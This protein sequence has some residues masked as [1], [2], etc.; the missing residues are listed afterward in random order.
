MS[1]SLRT[2]LLS[3]FIV[4][5]AVSSA[6]ASSVL[7]MQ[8]IGSDNGFWAAQSNWAMFKDGE[9][10]TYD[11]ISNDIKKIKDGIELYPGGFTASGDLSVDVVI[12][13][14][15]VITM[16]RNTN[17]A[18]G[19]QGISSI[20]ISADVTLNMGKNS[21][22]EDTPSIHLSQDSKLRINAEHLQA[23]KIKNP[24]TWEAE[25]ADLALYMPVTFTSSNAS[26]DV[27]VNNGNLTIGNVALLGSKWEKRVR[28]ISSGSSALLAF[29]V[30]K[31]V[32]G[33][34]LDVILTGGATRVSV[35]GSNELRLNVW[36]TDIMQAIS[37]DVSFIKTGTGTL[38]INKSADLTGN[39]IPA[40][41]ADTIT[42]NGGTLKITG[43]GKAPIKRDGSKVSFVVNDASILDLG[44]KTIS[45]DASVD[46]SINKTGKV[47]FS[48]A[49]IDNGDVY[50]GGKLSIDAE[51]YVTFDNT[52]N[53]V[54]EF[55]GSQAVKSVKGKGTITSKG[56]NAFLLLNGTSADIKNFSGTIDGLDI[57]IITS[58][59]TLPFLGTNA[60]A[61]GTI[62]TIYVFG[63]EG[64]L[65]LDSKKLAGIADINNTN[66]YLR[67]DTPGIGRNNYTLLDNIAVGI[68]VISGD[69]ALG[70][71]SVDG[72]RSADSVAAISFDT[73][74]SRDSRLVVQKLVLHANADKDFDASNQQA[75]NNNVYSNAYAIDIRGRGTFA[76][77]DIVNGA[78]DTE[79]RIG[80][81]DS[82]TV[83]DNATLELKG[84]VKFP[85][86]N[87]LLLKGASLDVA[88]NTEIPG[89][90]IIDGNSI[91]KVALTGANEHDFYGEEN[92]RD[93]AIQV[94]DMF[95]I[96]GSTD[97]SVDIV[98]L[99]DDG[100]FLGKMYSVLSYS[101]IDLA[102]GRTVANVSVDIIGDYARTVSTDKDAMN[103]GLSNKVLWAQLAKW[104]IK[105]IVGQWEFI[106]GDDANQLGSGTSQFMAQISYG[107]S[108]DITPESIDRAISAD[109]TL[110]YNDLPASPRLRLGDDRQD[111]KT[112]TGEPL[113][114]FMLSADRTNH[115]FILSG[116]SY[117]TELTTEIKLSWNKASFDAIARTTD[118]RVTTSTG[119]ALGEAF[120]HNGEVKNEDLVDAEYSRKL[121]NPEK[122][123]DVYTNQ[124]VYVDG[125]QTTFEEGENAIFQFI[126]RGMR[127]NPRRNTTY[128]VLENG[129]YKWRN[130]VSDTDTYT[131]VDTNGV[132]HTV[133]GDKIT[134][135]VDGVEIDL[136]AVSIDNTADGSGAIVSI[137][138]AL[139]GEAGETGS[140]F[141]DVV[142]RAVADDG[143]EIVA[144]K[145]SVEVV[146]AVNYSNGTVNEGQSEV[147]FE[148]GGDASETHVV[149]DATG[150]A[151]PL[152]GTISYD[153]SY[154]GVDTN[155]GFNWN[156]A[157]GVVAYTLSPDI[158]S[159]DYNVVVK[160]YNDAGVGYR[161]TF[162]V[163]VTEP[164]S[165]ASDDVP[166]I[167]ADKIAVT[168]ALPDGT[169][170]VTF[171]LSGGA[172]GLAIS[173]DTNPAGLVTLADNV[174]T[175]SAAGV[176]AGTYTYTFTATSAD[177]ITLTVT[178][179]EPA[180]VEFGIEEVDSDHGFDD[181]IDGHTYYMVFG[182]TG[183]TGEVTWELSDTNADGDTF[184]FNGELH[185]TKSG[186]LFVVEGTAV[187]GDEQGFVVKA[188]SGTET[189][190]EEYTFDVAADEVTSYTALD[191]ATGSH[192]AVTAGY[193]VDFPTG[194][195]ADED[196]VFLPSWLKPV[197][198]ADDEVI[199]VEFAGTVGE[200]ANGTTGKVRI[201]ATDADDEDVFYGWDVTYAAAPA[202]LGLTVAPTTLTLQAGTT[203]T[204]TLT[205]ANALGAVSY[206]ASQSWV[207]FSGNTAT[208]APTAAGSYDVTITATDAG[209]TSSNTATATVAVTVTARPLPSGDVSPDVPTT[210]SVAASR[211]TLSVTAGSTATVTLTPSN[212]LGTVSYRASQSWVTFSG[213]TATFAPTTSGDYTVTITATDAGRTTNNTATATVR[214][215]VTGGSS[216]G[217]E[218]TAPVVRVTGTRISNTNMESVDVT[219]D[220]D[221]TSWAVYVNGTIAEWASIAS[222]GARTAR[223]TLDVPSDLAEGDYA[224]TVTATNADGTST[225]TPVGSFT[226][227]GGGVGS[228]GGG[229]DAGF[230]A[231]ALALAAPLFL[232]RRRS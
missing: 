15:A 89:N 139:L 80:A 197:T 113:G 73:D 40:L 33:S 4:V 204:A 116:T 152:T 213:N 183:A 158:A 232:R 103:L 16:D 93:A 31:N 64:E 186:D 171:T 126:I 117:V 137:P 134:I 26:L 12:S 44:K 148:N 39:G 10:T 46:I 98:D 85:F 179:T 155:P 51:V 120:P 106:G 131:I 23:F 119:G 127:V 94:G 138:A 55:G 3:V 42:V 227:A 97:I 149:G 110:Y 99:D 184:T 34:S 76:P 228:S 19:L 145:I 62:D 129:V 67:S 41:S 118:V 78:T 101:S 54:L 169:D 160:V 208:F 100:K 205:P 123:A 115:L 151:T 53:G 6:M 150:E 22:F 72:T 221:V 77:K 154:N 230:G 180:P 182:A 202:A 207:T 71:V 43:E 108:E 105:P 11:K 63:P 61:D 206:T 29:D 24:T 211:T 156:N 172:T 68:L 164:S 199:G 185:S 217:E 107:V 226:V 28:L 194:V 92:S 87:S 66:I 121:R 59:D 192:T 215:T 135:T 222:T 189:V 218:T 133:T 187:T 88:N 196:S 95:K 193:R 17:V 91:I 191:A 27:I 163:H 58:W 60:S 7:K 220:K 132:S 1:K 122:A 65:H 219:A 130:A 109:I 70:T 104:L 50:N 69:I 45:T 170:T 225:R 13:K 147:T 2:F 82:V 9:E 167:T 79:I 201:E 142:L 203:A 195:V 14:D 102:S 111:V 157:D 75:R 144:P 209:R 112:S 165:G 136:A 223:V 38:I 56:S 181:A 84:G 21:W 159:G 90:F 57:G 176:A 96:V 198:N 18:G 81:Q 162:T 35:L 174:A 177:A 128:F 47:L 125:G 175:I 173:G 8:W 20:D 210:F 216:G 188:T 52:G 178:V 124:P 140:D 83:E 25:S 30:S 214:V 114:F 5:L 86:Y 36:S 168:V 224:I 161:Y 229:C 153:I 143:R 166:A 146:S 200:L 190:E 74:P 212:A 141:K 32:P 48:E 49:A 231:L 37:T